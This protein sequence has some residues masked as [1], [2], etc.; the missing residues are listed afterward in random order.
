MPSSN[1]LLSPLRQAAILAAILSVE[2]LLFVNALTPFFAGDDFWIMASARQMLGGDMK[3][4]APHSV[5]PLYRP[6]SRQL[7]FSL[8]LL[9]S[10][11]NPVPWHLVNLA[12]LLLLTTEVF[13]IARKFFG[14]LAG[15]AA[16]FFF[17]TRSAFFI[18]VAWISCIQELLSACLIFGSLIVW[19]AYIENRGV[20]RLS[21]SIVF[22]LLATGCKETGFIIPVFMILIMLF[23]SDRPSAGKILIALAPFIALMSALLIA[24]SI[25]VGSPKPGSDYEM[26]F[27]LQTATHLAAYAT[28]LFNIPVYLFYKIAGSGLAASEI[29]ALLKKWTALLIAAQALLLVAIAFTVFRWRKHIVGAWP[30]WLRPLAVGVAW[31]IVALA[32][33]ALLL[34]HGP[35]GY[36]A[37]LAI[38]GFGI[39]AAPI[40]R[41]LLSRRKIAI[42]VAAAV[43]LFAALSFHALEEKNMRT[44][45]GLRGEKARTLLSDLSVYLP[46][47]PSEISLLGVGNPEDRAEATHVINGW[48]GPNMRVVFPSK[49]EN[50]PATGLYWNDWRVRRKGP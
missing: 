23:K 10:P 49:E 2:I 19:L 39:G 18:T 43:L 4:L 8:M 11:R 37:L 26:G 16:A 31:F 1:N 32:P 29:M 7:Y 13:L 3:A 9:L 25:F 28:W 44:G 6:V 38:A 36:Y 27:S 22:A 35:A 21:I 47:T 24:R 12:L 14:S 41:M 20:W 46:R 5:D 50:A 15:L 45:W 17:G 48:Y 40:F 33:T 34:H 30:A 42:P